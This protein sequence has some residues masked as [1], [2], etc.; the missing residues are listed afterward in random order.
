M[1]TYVVSIFEDASD[2]VG[3][4][5]DVE[6]GRVSHFRGSEDL[7]TALSGG[8]SPDPGPGR[9]DPVDDGLGSGYAVRVEGST[10]RERALTPAQLRITYLRASRGAVA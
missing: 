5:R 8:R 6:S 2:L 7:V 9:E 10:T 3:V 4:V 1:A